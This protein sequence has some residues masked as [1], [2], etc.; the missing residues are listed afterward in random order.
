[1]ASHKYKPVLATRPAL[2][3]SRVC[4][5]CRKAFDM[6]V[7]GWEYMSGKDVFCSRPCLRSWVSKQR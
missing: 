1:M 3:I 2:L 5:H 4:K 6:P 7:D